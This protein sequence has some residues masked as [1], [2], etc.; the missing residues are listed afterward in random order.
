MTSSDKNDLNITVDVVIPTIIVA[1]LLVVNGFIF[2]YIMRRRRQYN[3][4]P[5]TEGPTT[6]TG[7]GFAAPTDTPD[8]RCEIE[9]ERL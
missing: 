2:A 3:N 6:S 1:V 9:M 5:L 4:L 7:V 8:D